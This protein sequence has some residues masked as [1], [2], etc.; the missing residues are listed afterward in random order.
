MSHHTHSAFGVLFAVITIKVIT[1]FDLYNNFLGEYLL[2]IYQTNKISLYSGAILGALIPDIDHINSHIAN[3]FKPLSWFIKLLGIKHRG[4]TH[5]LLGLILFSLLVKKLFYL[6]WISQGWYYSLILGYISH[7][8][9]D[10]FNSTGLP[11][12]FPLKYRFKFGFN[13]TTGSWQ[14]NLFFSIVI[15]CLFILLFQKPIHSILL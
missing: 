14:E 2:I 15:A 8:I 10:M 7:L 11:I 3:K 12:L 1:S 6:D 13:I 9:A 4:I 5:S